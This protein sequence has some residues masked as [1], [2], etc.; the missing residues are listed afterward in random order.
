MAYCDTIVGIG[1]IFR[2]DGMTEPRNDGWKDRRGSRNCYL[3]IDLL[4]AFINANSSL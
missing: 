1:A 3:D 2:T 4:M